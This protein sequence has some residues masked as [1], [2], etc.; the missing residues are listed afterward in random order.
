MNLWS[1]ESFIWVGGKQNFQL[2]QFDTVVTLK[3]NHGNWKWNE[4]VKLN[5]YYHHAK[6]GII[7][8]ASKK[9][10]TLSFLP[11]MDNQPA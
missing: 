10:A 6:Y 8:T 4:W 1:V 5:E 3:Y 7:Y 9:I 11:R 2:K